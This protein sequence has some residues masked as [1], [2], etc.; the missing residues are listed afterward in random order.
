[1]IDRSLLTA[2]GSKSHKI[3]W[4]VSIPEGKS[5]RHSAKKTQPRPRIPY[6]S[7]GTSATCRCRPASSQRCSALFTVAPVHAKDTLWNLQDCLWHGSLEDAS[8]GPLHAKN[9]LWNLQDCLWHGSLED[10]SLGSLHASWCN[11]AARRS[12]LQIAGPENRPLIACLLWERLLVRYARAAAQRGVDGEDQ[13]DYSCCVWYRFVVD[14]KARISH[15]H[16]LK[17]HLLEGETM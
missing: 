13:K 6:D 5:L 10:A 16:P 15:F 11:N 8:L 14:R 4:R 1:L 3:R 17:G 2:V 9:T 12:S 7:P